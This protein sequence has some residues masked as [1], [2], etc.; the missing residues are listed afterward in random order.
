MVIQ[1]GGKMTDS[2]S[3]P[4]ATKNL[5]GHEKLVNAKP[6]FRRQNDPLQTFK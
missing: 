2:K 6:L 4:S 1:Y 3:V 5:A